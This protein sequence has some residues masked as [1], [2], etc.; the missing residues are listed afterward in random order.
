MRVMCYHCPCRCVQTIAE[1]IYQ[2]AVRGHIPDYEAELHQ[3]YRSALAT[4]WWKDTYSSFSPEAY[5]VSS[6]FVSSR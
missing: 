1:G 6:V 3:L 5:F 2:L 4:G